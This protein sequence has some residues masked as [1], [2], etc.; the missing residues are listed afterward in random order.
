[1]RE[2]EGMYVCK[3]STSTHLSPLP[4]RGLLP[5][6]LPHH[7]LYTRWTVCKNTPSLSWLVVYLIITRRKVIHFVPDCFFVKHTLCLSP[8]NSLMTLPRSSLGL[9]SFQECLLDNANSKKSPGLALEWGTRTEALSASM[10]QVSLRVISHNGTHL[11][12]FYFTKY[13]EAMAVTEWAWMAT[14][15]AENVAY[16]ISHNE[17]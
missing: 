12:P 10:V 1:M 8:S 6:C 13:K 16:Q 17:T 14:Y 7:G 5:P 3:L 11:L 15:C 9:M 2:W 4:D